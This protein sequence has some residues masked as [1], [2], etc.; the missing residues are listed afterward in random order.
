M[1]ILTILI[2]TYVL[3]LSALESRINDNNSQPQTHYWMT[4]L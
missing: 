2:A 1:N 4:L 3:I